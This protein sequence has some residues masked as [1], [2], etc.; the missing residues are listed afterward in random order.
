M[1]DYSINDISFSGS[2]ENKID[3]SINPVITNDGKTIIF[4][5]NT[6]FS[7]NDRLEVRGLR[8][9]VGTTDTETS[10]EYRLSLY[11]QNPI[12]LSDEI[13]EIE[14][15]YIQTLRDDNYTLEIAAP[16]IEFDTY[17]RYLI[18][19]KPSPMTGLKIVDNDNHPTLRAEELITIKLGNT[20]LE[21]DHERNDT[22]FDNTSDPIM[23]N[24]DYIYDSNNKDQFQLMT[25]ISPP[26]TDINETLFLDSIYVKNFSDVIIDGGHL[27][28]AVRTEYT[29]ESMINSIIDPT[30]EGDDSIEKAFTISKPTIRSKQKQ[31]FYNGETNSENGYPLNVYSLNDIVIKDDP[32]NP[33]FNQKDSYGNKRD[34]IKILIPEET[35]N[36]SS[37][38]WYESANNIFINPNESSTNLQD[39]IE[40]FYQ[41]EEINNRVAATI[42]FIG[43]F[44]TNDS[45]VIGGL[46][47]YGKYPSNQ[48]LENLHNL[49]F[50]FN[51][52]IEGDF[53]D[54]QPL[55]LSD[56]KVSSENLQT[57]GKGVNQ[58]QILSPIQIRENIQSNEQIRQINK[59]AL[60]IPNVL[61]NLGV[62]WAT[63]EEQPCIQYPDLYPY[64]CEVN[65]NKITFNFSDLIDSEGLS[66]ENL[67]IV[68]TSELS[69]STIFSNLIFEPGTT[70]NN[71]DRLFGFENSVKDSTNIWLVSAHFE[72]QNG[73]DERIVVSNI[74]SDNPK[75]HRIQDIEIGNDPLLEDNF[76]LMGTNDIIS[77]EFNE[78]FGCFWDNNAI[79]TNNLLEIDSRLEFLNLDS[80]RISFTVLDSIFGD[81]EQIKNLDII[82]TSE[83]RSNLLLIKEEEGNRSVIGQNKDFIA[84]G[85]PQLSNQSIDKRITIDREFILPD[86]TLTNDYSNILSPSFNL[87]LYNNNDL[88]SYLIFNINQD[89]L[90]I[91]NNNLES[92]ELSIFEDGRCIEIKPN[93]F[94]NPDSNEN[95]LLSNVKVSF[96]NSIYDLP[97]SSQEVNLTHLLKLILGNNLEENDNSIIS[98]NGS[99]IDLSKTIFFNEPILKAFQGTP[100][101]IFNTLESH[102]NNPINQNLENLYFKF[103]NYYDLYIPLNNVSVD[104]INQNDDL[105][106][107]NLNQIQIDLSNV[108]ENFNNYADK[109]YL[110]TADTDII[111]YDNSNNSRSIDESNIS[112]YPNLSPNSF[113]FPETRKTNLSESFIVSFDAEINI[114]N[115]IFNINSVHDDDI[116]F[117]YTCNSNLV[118]CYSDQNTIHFLLPQI[119]NNIKSEE[120]GIFSISISL[121]TESGS[122]IPFERKILVDRVPDQIYDIFPQPGGEINENLNISSRYNYITDQEE[123]TFYVESSPV[124]MDEGNSIII[125][126]NPNYSEYQLD[127]SHILSNEINV[128]NK[129]T[130]NSNDPIFEDDII[131]FNQN[132]NSS[133]I[134][135]NSI[136]NSLQD[137]SG[138][139]SYDVNLIDEA[140]NSLDTTFTFYLQSNQIE[141]NN[142]FYNYPNPFSSIS[143]E[144][145]NFSYNIIDEDLFD[146][147]TLIVFDSSGQIVYIKN[148]DDKLYQGTHNIWWDG[149]TNNGKPLSNG[150]YFSIIKFNDGSKETERTRIN[151]VAIFNNE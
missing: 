56:L 133:F 33:I 51:N 75:T 84:I 76:V 142:R 140:G 105:Y 40:S 141:A 24:Y 17:N 71:Q 91:N 80:S 126:T 111:I 106:S 103:N 65:D 49:Q 116:S 99:N 93:D 122:S 100:Y 68:S 136:Y 82:C 132:L 120:N 63:D 36:D 64:D 147:A 92:N 4:S 55:F 137:K 131:S 13:L 145:T 149:K 48:D 97:L 45:L 104:Q 15:E 53:Q 70:I 47:V 67:A 10:N 107:F 29:P 41:F 21:F 150:V 95:L 81:F 30:L 134:I 57:I 50:E 83:G 85:S 148:L 115:L 27:S 143:N 108:I 112:F 144:G 3:L 52:T 96:T 59:G 72:N 74:S 32:N 43:T 88:S 2:A 69:D 8:M 38:T 117:T 110:S 18:H 77:L 127:L 113:I 66:I 19:D 89:S 22:F 101:L 26:P 98:M 28:L 130:F 102:F 73:M 54:L 31:V 128:L 146:K 119:L 94:P 90:K 124:Y 42:N 44:P 39:S 129:I 6:D 78:G 34:K 86:I 37:F 60:W 7:A 138:E 123:I 58:T 139:I 11:T 5:L 12:S 61:R 125:H 25:L 20:E 16:S 114:N 151:K 46:M 14:P 87:C 135:D 79:N 35:V 121:S 23:T 118:N 109:S 1:S 62:K 9:E